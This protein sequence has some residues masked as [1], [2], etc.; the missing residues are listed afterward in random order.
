ME[1]AMHDDKTGVYAKRFNQVFDYIERHLDDPLTVEQLSAVAHFSPYHFH[2]QFADYCGMPVGRYIQLMRLKRASYRLAFNPLE[3]IIDIA[4]DAGFQN[5]ESF[6]RAF[7]HAFGLTPSQFRKQPAWTDW[8]QRI[9]KQK[10]TRTQAMNVK[11]VDFPETQVAMLAHHGE[12][13]RVNET[14]ARFIEWRK[15]TGLS[16]VATSRTYGIAP[17]DPATTKAEDFRFDV[18]G[19]VVAPIQ[20]DNPFGVTNGTIPGGR[21][22]VVRHHGSHDSLSESGR[23][24]YRDWLPASGEELRDF[25]LYFHYL[26]LVH[27]V[28]VHELLTDIY[29]P[30]IVTVLVPQNSCSAGYCAG[31]ESTMRSE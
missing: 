7:K 21:C 24:L 9:P 25:P 26:N 1:E 14:A 2:R 29:L 15:A 10:H 17:H 20:K 30:L 5:P 28:A 3:K 12:S 22:A 13:E 6:S 31:F 18:C 8:H 19:T 4:L 11:I 23:Y 16:P 27:E